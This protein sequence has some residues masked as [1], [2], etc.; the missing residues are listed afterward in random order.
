MR[1]HPL[2]GFVLFLL[3]S[4]AAGTFSSAAKGQ[5][6]ASYDRQNIEGFTVFVSKDV[7]AR[8]DDG[9]GR[10]PLTV[11]ER[12]LNDLKRI[13]KPRIVSVLQT[14]PIWV[15]WDQVDRLT[16][17]AVARYYGGPAEGLL[18]M[19]GDPRKANNVEVLTLKRLAEI[20]S[21]GTPLQQVV[22][23]HEMAHVVHHR[24]LGWDNPELAATFQSAVDRKLYDE[25][26]DRL[27][28]RTRAYARTNAAEYFAELSTAFLDSC[29]YF[30]FNQQ[31]LRGYD[32]AGY[33]FVERVWREPERFQIIALK[34]N[35]PTAPKLRASLAPRASAEDERS[36][37]LRLDKIKV[38]IRAGKKAEAKTELQR[39]I[40]SYAGTEAASEARELLAEMN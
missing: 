25:V 12:E 2:W 37:M 10:R 15:E 11:L 30:P 40:I 16:P 22:I 4:L 24:L 23:L 26:K 7:S 29:N 20:R 9:Y 3:A 17:G 13:L 32:P 8:R 34:P 38:Q 18:K 28:Q 36:A 6:P 21:P 33:T 31:Q 14:V 1:L 35:D 19:G 27:G 39:L 5:T